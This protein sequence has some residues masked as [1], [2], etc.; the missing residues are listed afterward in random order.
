MKTKKHKILIT[1]TQYIKR[2]KPRKMGSAASIVPSQAK[3]N[4]E[5]YCPYIK[6]ELDTNFYRRQGVVRRPIYGIDDSSGR[7]LATISWGSFCQTKENSTSA[8]FCLSEEEAAIARKKD[9]DDKLK[10][11]YARAWDYLEWIFKETTENRDQIAEYIR[12]KRVVEFNTN[13][14]I[15]GKSTKIMIVGAK[16][17]GDNIDHFKESRKNYWFA[18]VPSK[19]L[20]ITP[21]RARL[22]AMYDSR[23][24]RKISHIFSQDFNTCGAC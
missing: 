24:L 15:D 2:D 12:N 3:C 10:Q 20:K 23:R 14:N 21:S 16:Y 17:K 7:V 5:K 19:T 9:N 13:Y 22:V 1:Q 6:T 18:K 4:L 11:E 8:S